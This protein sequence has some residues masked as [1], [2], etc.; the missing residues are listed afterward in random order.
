MKLPR[1]REGRE[2]AG[3]TQ[4]ELAERAGV[5]HDPVWRAEAGGSVSPST[6]R[7]L[8][9]ALGV[10]IRD[11]AQEPVVLPKAGAPP[12]GAGQE[13]KPPPQVEGLPLRTL[14]LSA[15]EIT[16]HYREAASHVREAREAL[17]KLP[18]NDS[19]RVMVE[20]Y[21]VKAE[22]ELAGAGAGR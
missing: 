15:P 19:K 6:A 14:G 3:F 1:L 17:K 16:E 18:E 5:S 11:L 21:L 7:K 9:G 12:R 10:E 22:K 2:L 13:E 8:A 4:L 20:P